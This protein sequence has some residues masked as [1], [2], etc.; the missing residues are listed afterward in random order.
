MRLVF[1]TSDANNFIS[2]VHSWMQKLALEFKELEHECF[3]LIFT[4]GDGPYPFVD[5]LNTHDFLWKSIPLNKYPYT[6]Q[7]TKWVIDE[8]LKLKA[9]AFFPGFSVAGLYAIPWLKK[10]GITTANFIHSDDSFWE[11]VAERFVL[12]KD[13]WWNADLTFA[14]S[15]YI[16]D[17]LAT[18]S[19]PSLYYS[20]Y[21]IAQSSMK[22]LYNSRPFRIVYIGRIEEEQ[23]RISDTVRGMIYVLQ[24]L[25][26]VAFDI[27]GSGSALESVQD[28]IRKEAKKLPICY[29]GILPNENV[30]QT[31]SNYQCLILLSDYEGLPLSLL[32]AMN[33][34][35]VPICMNIKSGVNEV[36]VDGKSGFIVNNR[37]SEVLSSIKKMLENPSLWS[38]CSSHAF[39]LIRDN[40]DIKKQAVTIQEKIINFKSSMFVIKK[41][42]KGFKIT[43]P[44]PHP[45][46]HYLIEDVRKSKYFLLKANYHKLKLA[47]RFKTNE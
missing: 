5:F 16:Y 33:C 11:A 39:N 3:F 4:I 43:F 14:V 9:D 38:D 28:I 42:S 44:P 32:E 19:V 41:Q 22:A 30:Y 2:G 46:L 24:N 37:D 6:P 12:N 10:N 18:Y 7:R 17:T 15:R 40:F 31:L 21:G 23:K 20:P 35:L 8:V 1:T 36:V 29:K 27:Y 25:P 47:L 26:N 13:F 34:G 45:M